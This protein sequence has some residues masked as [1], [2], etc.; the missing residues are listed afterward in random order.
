MNS[1]EIEDVVVAAVADA[2]QF[3]IVV[4]SAV[5]KPVVAVAVVIAVTRSH[6]TAEVKPRQNW[7]TDYSNSLAAVAVG[8]CGVGVSAPSGM[9]P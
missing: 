5:E 3:E 8:C 4:E 9:R 1:S 7:T 6:P 2:T